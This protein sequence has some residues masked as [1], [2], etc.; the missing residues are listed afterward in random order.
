MQ[1]M[2]TANLKADDV[3]NVKE[4]HGAKY[5]RTVS[6][7]TA[8]Y[9][10]TLDNAQSLVRDRT[11]GDC[12]C[13]QLDLANRDAGPAAVRS[14]AVWLRTMRLPTRPAWACCR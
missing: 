3:R 11:G 9:I 13:R 14:G 12:F 4:K 5:M 1:D 2:V 10:V 8:T 6:C 7:H